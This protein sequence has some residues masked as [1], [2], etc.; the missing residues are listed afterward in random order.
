MAQDGSEA[1]QAR[2]THVVAGA[3]GFTGRRIPPAPLF[4]GDTVRATTSRPWPRWDHHQPSMAPV[5]PSPATH[6][7]VGAE[8]KNPSPWTPRTP[9]RWNGRPAGRAPSSTPTGYGL[10]G[11]GPI[12]AR[13]WKTQNPGGRRPG[14]R[15]ETHGPRQHHQCRPG[16]PTPAPRGQGA[17]RAGGTGLRGISHAAIRPAFAFNPGGVLLNNTA[18]LLRKPQRTPD[19]ESRRRAAP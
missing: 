15:G 7:P 17:A 3:S 18:W 5:G 10:P 1:P 9:G 12:S 14:G 8:D 2:R 4:Q 19:E 13:Q 16:Q 6:G 11:T